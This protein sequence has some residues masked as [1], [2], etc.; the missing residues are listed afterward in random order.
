METDK[1]SHGDTETHWGLEEGS[2]PGSF[3]IKE[4][5]CVGKMKNKRQRWLLHDR[6]LETCSK[7]CLMPQKM[8]KSQRF[9]TK[10]MTRTFSENIM[11]L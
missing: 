10:F 1:D 8:N 3:R 9:V 2:L 7:G 5:I 6:S 4:I 11:H